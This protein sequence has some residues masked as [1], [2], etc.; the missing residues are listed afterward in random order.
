MGDLLKHHYK[1]R[2]N[3][4]RKQRYEIVSSTGDYG[5][6]E[7]ELLNKRKPNVGGL[8]FNF[9]KVPAK[10]NAIQERLADY[11]ISRHGNISSV[12]TPNP[13]LPFAWGDVKNPNTTFITNDAILFRFSDDLNEIELFI[14]PGKRGIT[15]QLYQ[16]MCDRLLVEE[17]D[18]LI[19]KS[20]PTLNTDT[21]FNV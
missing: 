10:F 9:G 17:M 16:M 8:S 15:M 7:R 18:D 21:M 6:F 11:C 12:Y 1:G 3:P 4:T 14:A 20:K 2:K 13:R 19:A 5:L